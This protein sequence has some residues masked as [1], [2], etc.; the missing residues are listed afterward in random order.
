MAAE[1]ASLSNGLVVFERRYRNTVEKK[2]KFAKE[3][4]I[5]ERANLFVLLLLLYHRARVSS[6]VLVVGKQLAEER[7]VSCIN[8][9]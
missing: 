1:R 4:L 5:R 2:D 3:F 6:F 8:R 9:F 7:V